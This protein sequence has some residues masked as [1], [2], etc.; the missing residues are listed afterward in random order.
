MLIAISAE[1]SSAGS[2]SF[3]SVGALGGGGCWAGAAA[4]TVAFVFPSAR[5]ML[6]LAAASGSVTTVPALRS[7][8][9]GLTAAVVGLL[10]ATTYRLGTANIPDRITLGIA[11]ASIVA[12]AVLGISAAWIVVAAGLLGVSFSAIPLRKQA[13]Q[14]DMP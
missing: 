9:N 5:L 2:T 13:G 1:T 10:L 12:G 3:R 11:L 6:A 8:I 7:A 4:A 14:G